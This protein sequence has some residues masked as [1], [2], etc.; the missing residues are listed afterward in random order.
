MKSVIRTLGICAFAVIAACGDPETNDARGYTKA[1]LE[2]PTVLI[3]GEEPTEMAMLREPLT[4]VIREVALP[5]PD[6][7]AA[8]TGAQEPAA[9]VEL[10][11]GV[12]QEM[13]TA[14]QQIYGSTGF[15]FTCHGAD[16]SGTPLAPALNDSEWLHIDG[17]HDAIMTIVRNGVPQPQQ[18]PAPMPPMGGA[19]LTDDQI[20]DVAAYVYTLSR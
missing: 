11:E 20:R 10:P 4:P 7:A 16:G 15:C 18:F 1:P 8:A 3:E 19:Q 14:G 6:T 17:S 12:T 2:H 5:A 9:P 13:V